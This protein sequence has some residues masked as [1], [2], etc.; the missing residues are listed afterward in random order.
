MKAAVTWIVL[1][2]ARAAP[3]AFDLGKHYSGAVTLVHAA[4]GATAA[5]VVG[6]V[7]GYHAAITK[8][9]LDGIARAGQRVLD[10]G[11]KPL[12]N[13]CGMCRSDH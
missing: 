12:H 9:T 6:A 1:A 7:S 11:L 10:D 5:F 13:G 2:T 3:I 8:P 4:Y